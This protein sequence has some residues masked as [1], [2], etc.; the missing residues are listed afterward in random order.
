MG[1]FS[2]LLARF[3]ADTTSDGK[4]MHA[5]WKRDATVSVMVRHWILRITLVYPGSG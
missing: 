2:F 1:D 5:S 3:N 4:W